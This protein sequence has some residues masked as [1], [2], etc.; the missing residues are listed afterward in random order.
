MCFSKEA[1]FT[2]AAVLGLV[3]ALTIKSTRS[4]NQ[5]LVAAIPLLFAIQ[6][7]SEGVLWMQLGDVKPDPALFSLAQKTFLMFAFFVWP[8]WIP[9]A[10]AFLE[11]ISW[12]RMVLFA[13][14]AGGTALSATNLLY[15]LN[16]PAIQVQIA[17]HS[18]QYI[19]HAPEQL[20][21]Y[22]FLVLAPWFVSSTS[23]MWAVG[24]IMLAAW[25]VAYY[26]YSVTFVSVWCFFCAL[27]SS[28]I[29]W[30]LKSSQATVRINS[31]TP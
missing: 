8:I 13:L 24:T 12:R 1:S 26:L 15:F 25:V 11:Q 2:A 30:A 23:R 16:D 22:P 4:R 27:V 31:R 28:S 9:L 5:L 14:L 17:N 3:G 10:L 19:G 6:Q 20:F 29:Y 7:F 18:I 21:L